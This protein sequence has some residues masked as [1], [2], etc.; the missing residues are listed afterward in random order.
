MNSTHLQLPPL[1]PIIN[2]QEKRLEALEV[3]WRQQKRA[4]FSRTPALLEQEFLELLLTSLD[5]GVSASYAKLAFQV[6]A[7]CLLRPGFVGQL[8]QFLQE[9]SIDYHALMFFIHE[10]HFAS[11]QLRQQLLPALAELGI[12]VWVD[13]YLSRQPMGLE[14][15]ASANV[16]G[17]RV[18]ARRGLGS[19]TQAT[20]EGFIFGLAALVQR[21]QKQLIVTSL[22]HDDFLHQL[23]PIK[24]ACLLQGSLFGE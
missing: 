19:V 17:I 22:D 6:P 5:E 21:L 18:S 3:C 23:K 16:N 8:Q 4:S 15:L 10:T 11:L 24:G 7:P 1:Q 2:W 12:E 20:G 9:H 14:L 13:D